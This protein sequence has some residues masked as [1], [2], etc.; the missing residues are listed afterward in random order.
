MDQLNA[1]ATSETT[2][3][4]KTIP[5]SHAPIYSNKVNMKGWLR[6]PNDIRRP[7]PTGDR[8]RACW[9]T[10]GGKRWTIK[11]IEII[12]FLNNKYVYIGSATIWASQDKVQSILASFACFDT[13]STWEASW[14]NIGNLKKISKY[15][16]ISSYCIFLKAFLTY[17]GLLGI[18]TFPKTAHLRELE[19]S[20]ERLADDELVQTDQKWLVNFNLLS[21]TPCSRTLLVST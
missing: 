15:S 10:G 1:G 11:F 2:R 4:W 19:Q 17:L 21:T 14:W 3:T 7:V 20:A 16:S 18:F 6:R 9:V 5:T 13:L 8:T 12:I